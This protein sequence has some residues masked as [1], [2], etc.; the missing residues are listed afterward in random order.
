MAEQIGEL[1]PDGVQRL[2]NQARWDAD[3]VRDDLRDYVIE[4][5]GTPSSAL[6]IAETGFPKK[7]TKSVGV[8]RQRNPSVGRTK[9]CQVGAFL[10][11][12]SPRGWAFI[13]RAL[14]LPEEW[15]KD[16]KRCQRAG[17]PEGAKFATKGEL[18]QTMLERA[19]GADVPAAW[20][21][22]GEVYG[23]DE[24][25]RRWLR[26]RRRPYVLAVE[27]SEKGLLTKVDGEHVS[28]WTEGLNFS[29]SAWERLKVGAG[30]EGSRIYEWARSVAPQDYSRVGAVAAR[31]PSGNA[32][33]RGPR[34]LLSGLRP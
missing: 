22:G 30:S 4:R 2:L 26:G 8:A 13:D 32:T 16:E 5:L 23:K 31:S 20:V 33:Q 21:T 27:H 29:A 24:G 15:A 28:G 19:F 1:R 7:G 3:L 10:A 17:V 12:A 11:Y 18:A 14:Y 34:L 25:L 6:V 9:N